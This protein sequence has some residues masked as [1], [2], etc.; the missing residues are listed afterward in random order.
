M[1]PSL[2]TAL[3][4][5]DEMVAKLS[6]DINRRG[7]DAVVEEFVLGEGDDDDLDTAWRRGDMAA[8]EHEQAQIKQEFPTLYEKLLPERNR[9]WLPRLKLALHGKKNVMVLVGVAHLGGTEGLLKM[10]QDAGFKPEQ[11]YGVVRP[12]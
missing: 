11:L 3:L 6:L 8:V 1:K 4:L 9:K 7:A 12:D 2:Q 5:M 10:L